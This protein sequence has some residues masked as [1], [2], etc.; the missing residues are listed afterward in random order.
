ME[1]KNL[2][3]GNFVKDRGN[4]IIRVDFMEYQEI[5]YS[6]KFGQRMFL[7]KEEV[8][9]MTEYTDYANPIILD[10]KWLSD[11]GFNK[12]EDMGGWFKEDIVFYK[13]FITDMQRHKIEYVHELQNLFFA[14]TG[15]ELELKQ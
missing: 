4:K 12:N 5:G 15:N 14:L 8:H 11:F 9:P 7:C 1:A 10:E 13:G 2:R 3:I 6:V